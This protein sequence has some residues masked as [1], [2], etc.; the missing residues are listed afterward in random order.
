LNQEQ[1]QLL[2]QQLT[3]TLVKLERDIERHRG[4]R[5]YHI[6]RTN[7][8]VKL[9]TFFLLSIGVFNV[10]YVYELY[11]RMH[12]IVNT[13][14]DLQ[15]DVTAVSGNMLHLTGTM[16]KFDSHL[17]QMPI[18]SSSAAS[19]SEQMPQLNQSMGKMVGTMG[20]LNYEMKVMSSDTAEIN[21]RFANITQ[22]IDVMG[23]NVKEISGPM[24]A[25][26]SF[27]P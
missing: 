1:Q 6:H 27:M 2:N 26:N 10:L 20:E 12:E 17:E 19:M 5:Q 7:L 3:S 4:E 14:T 24:G 9:V 15:A 18:I 23:G 16:Q 22:G 11:I 13:I 8:L 25:F 21:R